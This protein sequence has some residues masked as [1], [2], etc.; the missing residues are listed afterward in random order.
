MGLVRVEPVRNY[1]NV[2][3]MAFRATNQTKK[4]PIVKMAMNLINKTLT[5][6]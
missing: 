3:T 1:H 5:R 6:D 2:N 4:K